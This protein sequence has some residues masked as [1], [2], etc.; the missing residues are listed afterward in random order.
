MDEWQRMIMDQESNAH[1]PVEF[2][3]FNDMSPPRDLIVTEVDRCDINN[4]PH[5]NR[6]RCRAQSKSC[7]NCGCSKA[8]IGCNDSCGCRGACGNRITKANMDDFFGRSFNGKPHKLHPCFITALQQMPDTF[9]EQLTR[10]N[11]FLSLKRAMRP[12]LAGYDQDI[13]E[14]QE[15]WNEF[16]T[17]SSH[18]GRN[19]PALDDRRA[20][21]QRELL[22]IGLLGTHNYDHFFSFCKGGGGRDDSGDAGLE[23]WEDIASSERLI[24]EGSW[25]QGECTWHC[26]ACGECNDW[27]QWHCGTCKKCTYGMGIPCGRCSGVS[28]AYDASAYM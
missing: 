6:C 10:D 22:C 20:E 1:L 7:R 8:G 25:Q 4:K 2:D 5:P 27:R 14:W 19:H 9:F 12:G 15:K 17:V 21:L 23:G 18:Y 3:D 11:L 28:S 16:R 26:S 24:L 13:R